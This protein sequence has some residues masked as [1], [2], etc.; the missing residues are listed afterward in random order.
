MEN[1]K[2]SPYNV[3]LFLT[4][5]SIAITWVTGYYVHWIVVFLAV[6]AA[7]KVVTK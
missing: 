7:S 5:G 3:V 6:Y 2:Q 4:L 1:G